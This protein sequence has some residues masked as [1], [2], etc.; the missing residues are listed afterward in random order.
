M[1]ILKGHTGVVPRLAFSPDG[2]RL[3]SAE[4]NGVIRVWRFPAGQSPRLAFSSDGRWLAVRTRNPA[5]AAWVWD[6]TSP[7]RPVALPLAQGAG[8]YRY[9]A[10]LAFTPDG[11]H[12]VTAGVIRSGWQ[13]FRYER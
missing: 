11:Q 13:G 10:A 12:L 9:L 7:N 5:E 3:A 2:A 1:R 8:T 4:C 6:L